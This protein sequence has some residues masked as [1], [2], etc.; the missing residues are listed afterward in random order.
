MLHLKR[1]PEQERRGSP[2][3]SDLQ[4]TVAL[5]GSALAVGNEPLGPG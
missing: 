1:V 5:R 3:H 4:G 2:A